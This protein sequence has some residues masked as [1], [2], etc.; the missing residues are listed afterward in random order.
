[1][2]LFNQ[3]LTT[4]FAATRY[5]NDGLVPI[6]VLATKAAAVPWA[7]FRHT[8]PT[9][10]DIYRWFVAAR[11]P[12]VAVLTGLASHLVVL[13]F[14]QPALYD[15][16]RQQHPDLAR[17]FTVATPRGVH[18]WFHLPPGRQLSSRRAPGVDLLAE[19]R[20]AVAPPSRL[21]NGAYTVQDDTPRRF[22]DAASADAINAF[23]D[24]LQAETTGKPACADNLAAVSTTAQTQLTA[25]ALQR[26]YLDAAPRSGRNNAL[27]AAACVA[28]DCGWRAADV[29]D[30][31][32]DLH[33]VQPPSPNHPPAF[34]DRRETPARRRAE[35]LRTVASAFSRP[36][37]P[38]SQTDAQAAPRGSRQ[39]PNSVRERLIAAGQTHTVRV[40]EALRLKGI[41]PG[42]TFTYSQA[43]ELLRGTV[44][45]WSLRAALRATTEAGQPVIAKAA[46]DGGEGEGACAVKPLCER[47][48][49]KC[50]FEP[51]QNQRKIPRGRP[52][53]AYIMPAN[54]DLCAVLGVSPT[55]ADPLS[56]QDLV[57]AKR[58]RMALH[59]ELIRRRPGPYPR[60]WLARRLGLSTDTIDR[61]NRDIPIRSR[62]TFDS[63]PIFRSTVDLIPDDDFF[64]EARRGSFLEDDYGKRYPPLRAIA[65]RLLRQRRRVVYKTRWVNEYWYEDPNAPKPAQSPPA[66]ADRPAFA[67]SSAC[68][69]RPLPVTAQLFTPA[70]ADKP[71]FADRPALPG[72]DLPPRLSSQTGLPS[73]TGPLAQTGL[74]S[75]KGRLARKRPARV[76]IAPIQTVVPLK[77]QQKYL[78]RLQRLQVK[79]MA[80]TVYTAIQ[81]L[82]SDRSRR[83]S[84]ANARQLVQTYGVTAV[85][86]ALDQL[87]QQPLERITSPVGWLIAAAQREYVAQ[88]QTP[89][90]PFR[91]A[92]RPPK[93]K[94]K[95]QTQP[96]AE[97]QTQPQ[98]E[99]QAQPQAEPQTQ[100]QAEP[101]AQPQTESQT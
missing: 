54:A 47:D 93:R 69:H 48:Q 81:R 40:I 67:N 65:R 21:Q 8:R 56:P 14:D 24:A 53:I 77:T 26:L 75:Q 70:F 99:P 94:P 97:S 10:D 2:S 57:S 34:A 30:A 7:D 89:A 39:L 49:K 32:A 33:V 4:A 20:Y 42:Q 29:T 78:K 3:T 98:A 60:A 59:R 74:P 45:D 84:K 82:T 55:F 27:F 51:P 66:F 83:I 80:L 31:L 87:G 25:A 68:A 86:R 79:A 100:P 37:R 52:P 73:Q 18:L 92:R 23:L 35:A 6:P 19:G 16:F 58:T 88:H 76:P 28:R 101:Q 62:P 85:G 90:P 96:Q 43:L 17:T 44:G 13:D 50:T 41:Q 5:L 46:P 63:I 72:F 91:G 71:A 11:H 12:G 15:R 9:Q 95:S 1:M 61:Y 64:D 36:P 38:P 22:L